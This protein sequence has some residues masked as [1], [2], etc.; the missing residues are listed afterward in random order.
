MHLVHNELQ[1]GGWSVWDGVNKK[2]SISVA[3]GLL[4]SRNSLTPHLAPWSLN[5]SSHS[6]PS[7]FCLQRPIRDYYFFFIFRYLML[8]SWNSTLMQYLMRVLSFY[9]HL[10]KTC[11][12]HIC[13]APRTLCWAGHRH[14]PQ[15]AHCWEWDSYQAKV[16]NYG[17][18]GSIL[19]CDS[20]DDLIRDHRGGS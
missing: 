19:N 6:S 10:L 14:Y 11:M 2:N 5:P 8:Y 20:K 9:H 15:D 1:T 13:W 16:E 18:Y 3:L 7:L 12:Y 4:C 17:N